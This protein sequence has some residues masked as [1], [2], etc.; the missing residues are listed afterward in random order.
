MVEKQ[1]EVKLKTGLQARPAALFVQEANRFS[2]DIFLEKDGKKVNAKSIMG[3]MSLAV[4]SGVV[5]NIV[6]DGDD[7]ERAITVLS[8]FIQKEH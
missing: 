2:S 1:V 6:A 8:E 3:L 5:I 7:E 4:G